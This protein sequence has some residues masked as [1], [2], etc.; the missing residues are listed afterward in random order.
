[1]KKSPFSRI[2]AAAP[3]C[4]EVRENMYD[5]TYFKSGF[6]SSG[7]F[8]GFDFFSDA[9]R[10]DFDKFMLA[11]CRLRS[12]SARIIKK[13]YNVAGVVFWLSSD[14]PVIDYIEARKREAVNSFWET[15]HALIT[16]GME[17][18]QMRAALDDLHR[19]NVAAF[20]SDFEKVKC[21]A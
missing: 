7:L 8:V 9:D 2:I 13:S 1:M 21:A 6:K 10:A 5:D 3:R 14:A 15:R 11:A 12:V 16:D 20:L 4:A 18:E 17:P 19:E